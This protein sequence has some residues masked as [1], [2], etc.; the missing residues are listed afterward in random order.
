MRTNV[1]GGGACAEWPEG[2]VANNDYSMV[3][4]QLIMYNCMRNYKCCY[5]GGGR[6]DGKHYT[7]IQRF[8]IALFRGLA[9]GNF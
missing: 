3:L 7:V 2:G 9:A 8:L 4:P 1:P 5:R 6:A